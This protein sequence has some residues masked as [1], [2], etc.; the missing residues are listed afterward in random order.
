MKLLQMAKICPIQSRIDGL[1]KELENSKED[2]GYELLE[3]CA[4]Y[5]SRYESDSHIDDCEINVRQALYHWI[6]YCLENNI[7]LPLSDKQENKDDN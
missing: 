6:N 3:L 7:E 1:K 4:D 2:W 5:L